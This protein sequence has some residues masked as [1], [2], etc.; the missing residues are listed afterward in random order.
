VRLRTFGAGTH[1]HKDGDDILG[2]CFGQG[3]DAAESVLPQKSGSPAFDEGHLSH[4]EKVVPGSRL[5]AISHVVEHDREHAPAHALAELDH[6]SGE[7]VTGLRQR[8]ND[9]SGGVVSLRNRG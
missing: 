5:Q 7:P 8:L 9:A 1:H 4:F 6:A 2:I 3:A